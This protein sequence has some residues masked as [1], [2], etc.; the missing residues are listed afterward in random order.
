M[1]RLIALGMILVFT[2]GVLY[3]GTGHRDRCMKA[4]N[5][6]CSVLPWSGSVAPKVAGHGSRPSI[7]SLWNAPSIWTP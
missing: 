1:K 7:D 2:L 5:V 3:I 6:R 4:G